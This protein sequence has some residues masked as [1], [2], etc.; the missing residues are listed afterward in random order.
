M[1]IE[2]NI[3]PTIKEAKSW[4][5][6]TSYHQK[7]NNCD[8]TIRAED[9]KAVVPAHPDLSQTTL[10]AEEGGQVPKRL[11]ELPDG[12]RMLLSYNYRK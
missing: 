4:P 7:E 3:P 11:I 9:P 10:L 12:T 6:V 1:Q 8:L 2:K 5:I